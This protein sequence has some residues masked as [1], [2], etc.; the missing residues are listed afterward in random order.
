MKMGLFSL[1]P[2]TV[3]KKNRKLITKSNIRFILF[4]PYDSG[5]MFQEIC[6]PSADETTGCVWMCGCVSG[7]C[8]CVCVCDAAGF[9]FG[10]FLH[11][12]A[13]R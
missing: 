12:G 11:P 9:G 1:L 8:V 3:I 2:E 10:G 7:V 13:V 6:V 5:K 4:R